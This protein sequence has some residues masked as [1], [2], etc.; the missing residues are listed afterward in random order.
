MNWKSCLPPETAKGR[1]VRDKGKAPALP[2]IK[3]AAVRRA[4]VAEVV[5]EVEVATM[6]G[7]RERN[8]AI[9]RSGAVRPALPVLPEAEH[10]CP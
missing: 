5:A 1:K 10:R 3:L 7:G 8:F 4:V 2:V 6:P 9:A